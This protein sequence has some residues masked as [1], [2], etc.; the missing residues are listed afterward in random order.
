MT[1]AADW[2]PRQMSDVDQ[3]V[4][5]EQTTSPATGAERLA[6]NPIC[7]RPRARDARAIRAQRLPR[8]GPLMLTRE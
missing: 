5:T 3:R 6:R 7:D 2:A 8:R 4:R 1:F